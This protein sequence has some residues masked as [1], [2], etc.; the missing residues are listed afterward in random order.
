MIFRRL[1]EYILQENAIS[2]FVEK[3]GVET[4]FKQKLLVNFTNNYKEAGSNTKLNKLL[5]QKNRN[6]IFS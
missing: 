4:I 5:K 2:V 1:L 3:N 6:S